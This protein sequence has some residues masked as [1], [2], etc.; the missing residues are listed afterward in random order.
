MKLFSILFVF[1]TFSL[2][3]T[4]SPKKFCKAIK[5]YQ[6]SKISQMLDT[7]STLATVECK[8]ARKN[9]HSALYYYFTRTD[10]LNFEVVDKFV[11]KGANLYRAFSRDTKFIDWA[12]T[13]NANAYHRL[14][15]LM[16][17]VAEFA[18]NLPFENLI[19]ILNRNYKLDDKMNLLRRLDQVAY[20]FKQVDKEG[21]SL[22]HKF[23]N[24]NDVLLGELAKRQGN[25]NTVNALGENIF[26]Y[27]LKKNYSEEMKV[28]YYEMVNDRSRANAD[29]EYA[30]FYA[31]QRNFS[32]LYDM[33]AKLPDVNVIDAKGQTVLWYAISSLTNT[34]KLLDDSRVNINHQNDI[35]R[36]AL[37]QAIINGSKAIATLYLENNACT[38]I[39]DD[40]GKTALAY[41]LEKFSRDHD[42]IDYLR[43]YVNAESCLSL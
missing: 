24:Y 14:T 38:N 22:L 39:V 10:N 1:I 12:Y 16:N 4:A 36:T 28:A 8:V 35:G 7:D 34:R 20:N 9:Y 21:N 13:N 6:V 30:I 26:F 5:R 11:Q 17:N 27:S 29:G 23:V 2:S 32:L 33:Y 25:V 31:F 15:Y 18:K 19:H 3:A 43:N 42:F 41:A 40:N 37:M